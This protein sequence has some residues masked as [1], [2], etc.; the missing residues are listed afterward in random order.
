M[1]IRLVVVRTGVCKRRDHEGLAP[2]AES[3]TIHLLRADLSVHIANGLET[4]R[5]R[6]RS[7]PLW[8]AWQEAP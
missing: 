6:S 2:E 7:Q 4:V 1:S 3:A 8:Q 5:A